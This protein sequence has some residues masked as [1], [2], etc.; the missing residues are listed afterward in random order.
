M[1]LK[2]LTNPT[3]LTL[4]E[5]GLFSLLEIIHEEET[6]E[7]IAEGFNMEVIDITNLLDSLAAKGFLHVSEHRLM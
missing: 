2:P 3:K 7:R 1:G 6:I 5:Y 4:E